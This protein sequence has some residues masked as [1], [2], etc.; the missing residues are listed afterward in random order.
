MCL[1]P[2]VSASHAGMSLGEERIRVLDYSGRGID[3]MIHG[4]PDLDLVLNGVQ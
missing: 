3:E 4:S 1:S 2:L